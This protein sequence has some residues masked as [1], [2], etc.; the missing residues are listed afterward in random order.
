MGWDFSIGLRPNE[1]IDSR[2][3]EE[4]SWSSSDAKTGNRHEIVASGTA[5]ST[6]Y[7]ALKIAKPGE[8]ERI[9]ALVVLTAKRVG[10]FGYKDMDETMGPNE[11][12]CPLKVLNALT[13]TDNEHAIRWRAACRAYHESRAVA[14]Q[15]A[16]RISA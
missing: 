1:T 15:L 4:M 7:A 12:R 5:G 11:T 10:E 2:M 8:P 9:V 14:R 13:P 3:R 6:W 16:K